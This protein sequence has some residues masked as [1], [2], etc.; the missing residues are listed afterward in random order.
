MYRDISNVGFVDSKFIAAFCNLTGPANVPDSVAYSAEVS[1]IPRQEVLFKK[2]SLKK[3]VYKLPTLIVQPPVNSVFNTVL[4]LSENA[5]LTF[6][7]Q[8][9]YII[10]KFQAGGAIEVGPQKA[11]RL[12]LGNIVLHYEPI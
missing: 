6:G 11:C 7:V 8:G 1:S 2:S 4:I 3:T 5:S 12:I 9:S 10:G